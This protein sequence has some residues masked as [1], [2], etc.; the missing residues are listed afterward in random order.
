MIFYSMYK[1][2]MKGDKS[3]K[4]NTAFRATQINP[5]VIEDRK[6]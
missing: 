4:K 2:I 5:T 1:A 3:M 6:I